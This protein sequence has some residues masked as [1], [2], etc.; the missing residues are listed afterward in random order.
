MD[1]APRPSSSKENQNEE[2]YVYDINGQDVSS[3]GAESESE[4]DEVEDEV[5]FEQNVED[6]SEE[7]QSEQ[8]YGKDYKN[9]KVHLQMK[10]INFNQNL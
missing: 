4:N 2:R 6:M 8:L 5:V 7:T 9:E 1:D 3:S 10:I